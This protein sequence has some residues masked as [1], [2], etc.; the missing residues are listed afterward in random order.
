MNKQRQNTVQNLC[1]VIISIIIT[2][3][4]LEGVFRVLVKPASHA[5]TPESQLQSIIVFD[6]VLESFYRPNAQTRIHSQYGEFTVS[7]S[8]NELGLRDAS[9]VSRC[10]NNH[11]RI[12]ALGNS[13][14]EGWG[15]DLP[16]AFIRIAEHTLNQNAPLI[17]GKPVCIINGGIS[18]FGAAQSYLLMKRLLPV[19]K[20]DTVVFF[21]LPTMVHA[22]TKFLSH[23]EL[24]SNGTALRV[25]THALLNE[26]PSKLPASQNPVLETLG[27]YSAIIQFFNT[28]LENYHKQQ[29]IKPGDP[30]TDLLAGLRGNNLQA[31]HTPSLQHVE[32]MAVLARQHRISFR[33]VGV[34]LPQQLSAW[35]W[36]EG[37]RAYDLKPVQYPMMDQNISTD[38]YK[39]HHI[40]YSL[41]QPFLSAHAAQ[42]PGDKKIFYND[43]F[44]LNKTGNR[45]LGE[46]LAKELVTQARGH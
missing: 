32:A 24:D 8:L 9:I 16:D 41:A 39:S 43:D 3:G 26:K 33:V 10:Q 22:D 18:G 17:F 23:A 20:P 46:W 21:Y 44:H 37:R 28:R 5:A 42:N 11:Y 19:V 30:M 14:V 35:E 4:L 1:L 6:P 27:R 15:V 31:L 12:L 45:L 7:Y 13:F 40:A 25:N 29:Q 38:F 2:L 34:P 36:Q